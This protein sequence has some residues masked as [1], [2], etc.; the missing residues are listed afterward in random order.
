[1]PS[2]S[3]RRI[4]AALVVLCLVAVAALGALLL[5]ADL[6]RRAVEEQFQGEQLVLADALSRQVEDAIKD[7]IEA[8]DSVDLSE[9][10]AAEEDIPGWLAVQAWVYEMPYAS[11]ARVRGPDGIISE[12]GSGKSCEPTT[13]GVRLILD[14][15]CLSKGILVVRGPVEDGLQVETLICLTKIYDGILAPAQRRSGY[16]WMLGPG[17]R[18][19]G[20]PDHE[21]IGSRPFEG[22]TSTSL[23]AMLEAMVDGEA[24][25][26]E[27]PWQDT[28]RLAAYSPIKVHPGGISLAVSDDASEVTGRV[29]EVQQIQLGVGAVVLAAALAAVVLFSD[30]RRR[31]LE[32]EKESLSRQLSLERAAAHSERLARIGTLT[33]GVAHEI[34]GPLTVLSMLADELREDDPTLGPLMDE[35]VDRLRQISEDLTSFAR[36]GEDEGCSVCDPEAAVRVAARMAKPRI[37][38]GRN[39]P[40]ELGPMPQVTMDKGRLV[41][42]LMNLLFN[43]GDVTGEGDTIRVIGC[44]RDGGAELRVED[45]GPGVP[46]ALWEQIFEPFVTTKGDGEGTGLGLYL[47]R[48]MIQAAGGTLALDTSFSSGAAFV[49]WL[50]E[51]VSLESREA[52]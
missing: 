19:L 2:G 12:L 45:N 21:H 47:C 24:G 10:P 27:Y 3:L 48:Q 31:S 46:E 35:A 51:A 9:L 1:M 36:R 33:A 23:S 11:R 43:A 18:I 20:S 34:R 25:I 41:Q 30:Q 40:V 52:V 38:T 14:D 29:R 6:T 39:L 26:G 44:S 15:D 50:P 28:R 5:S 42:V 17:R 22:V 4:D 8:L 37:Q 32:N 13:A 16:A 7:A 49:V